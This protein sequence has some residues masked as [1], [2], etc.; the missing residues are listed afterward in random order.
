[1]NTC[2]IYFGDKSLVISES[3]ENITAPGEKTFH[4]SGDATVEAGL[5]DH[6]AMTGRS[7]EAIRNE[8]F[9]GYHLIKAGGGVVQ[10][11]KNELLLILRRNMWDLPKGKLDEGETIE[12]CAL[13]EVRE[14]TGLT[15]LKM[16]R[17]L[18]IT[19]HVYTQ[20]N[21]QILKESHWFLMK[22]SRDEDP[23]PQT[24]EEIEVVKWVAIKDLPKY[25]SQT[26]PSIRN[27][28]EKLKDDIN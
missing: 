23:V 9:S 16:E 2:T 24:E 14:E 25:Y 7:M 27:I 19:Y 4:I 28:F 5:S 20:D 11:S 15:Q 3:A 6:S 17:P 1:M 22:Y 13:R 21:Q 18:L 8:I 26:F 10:N 12:E